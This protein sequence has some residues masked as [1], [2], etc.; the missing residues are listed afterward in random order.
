MGMG[1]GYWPAGKSGEVSWAELTSQGV[2]AW[3]GGGCS[4]LCLANDSMEVVGALQRLLGY[5][6]AGDGSCSRLR[7]LNC[8]PVHACSQW[9]GLQ[10]QH[11]GRLFYCAKA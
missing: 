2:M 7:Q 4:W 10:H 5:A 6:I 8:K 1:V 3:R 9:S 11:S